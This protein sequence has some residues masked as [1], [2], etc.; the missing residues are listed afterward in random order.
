[1][2]IKYRPIQCRGEIKSGPIQAYPPIFNRNRLATQLQP[3][4]DPHRTPRCG[5]AESAFA[6]CFK[7]GH[8]SHTCGSASPHRREAAY[9]A[10]S[11]SAKMELRSNRGSGPPDEARF[12]HRAQKIAHYRRGACRSKK[13]PHAYPTMRMW[14]RPHKIYRWLT[15]VGPFRQIMGDRP[16]IDFATKDT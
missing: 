7:D 8:G 2:T 1:M 6:M 3:N 15:C 5:Y 4:A 12:R 10:G 13:S 9:D 16:A 11:V 14:P